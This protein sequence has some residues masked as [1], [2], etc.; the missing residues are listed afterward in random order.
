MQ[1]K[2]RAINGYKILS[3]QEWLAAGLEHG[4]M[5][6]Q[7][8]VSLEGGGDWRKVYPNSELKL[9]KQVHGVNTIVVAADDVAKN[10]GEPLAADGW[11]VDLQR[12]PRNQAWGIKTAD[13]APIIIYIKKIQ[14]AYVLHCGWRG[15][16]DNYLPL[17]LKQAFETYRCTAEDIEICIGPS[18][19]VDCYDVGDDVLAPAEKNFLAL[20][21]SQEALTHVLVKK[22]EKYYF[23]NSALLKEQSLLLG[24]PNTNIYI[25]Q[26]CTIC[27]KSYFSFRR[28]G[29]ASGRQVSFVKV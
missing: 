17:V 2:E 19:G 16:V 12:A 28:Q 18:A 6:S 8:D 3:V 23:N 1:I 5:N 4:F 9:L 14:I 15:T 13:C 26:D 25:I 27:D 20:G 11:C 29:E 21:G 7:L 10:S 22:N 24:V